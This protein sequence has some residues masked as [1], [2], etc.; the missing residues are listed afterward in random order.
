MQQ[1]EVHGV[2]MAMHWGLHPQ[3]ESVSGKVR[4]PNGLLEAV[5]SAIEVKQGFPQSTTLFSLYRDEV[6]H[7]IE[8][9][10]SSG[11]CLTGIGIQIILYAHDIL[12]TSNTLEVLHRH[13]N[14]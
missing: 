6:S 5:F 1:L 13:L 4:S 11:A 3:Y 7:Y 8:R 12:L 2:P 10:G 9:F 14:L